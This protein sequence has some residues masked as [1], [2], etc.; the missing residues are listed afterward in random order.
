M[1]DSGFERGSLMSLN[2]EFGLLT[3]TGFWWLSVFSSKHFPHATRSLKRDG[4]I[5]A[6]SRENPKCFY[7]LIN[8]RTCYKKKICWNHRS[9]GTC[10]KYQYGSKCQNFLTP[11]I[12]GNRAMTIL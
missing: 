6:F 9:L 3:S 10:L 4:S 12:L 11:Q 2:R 5:L 1:D 7:C 8:V